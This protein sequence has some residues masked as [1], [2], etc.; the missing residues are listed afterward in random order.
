MVTE[1]SRLMRMARSRQRK[2]DKQIKDL[3]YKIQYDARHLTIDKKKSD[4]YIILTNQ[5]EIWDEVI[6]WLDMQLALLSTE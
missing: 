6:D 4:K 3:E 2:L 5:Y 1:A